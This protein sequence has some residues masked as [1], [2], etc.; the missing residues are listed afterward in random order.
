MKYLND[1]KGELAL[2]VLAV[3]GVCAIVIWAVRH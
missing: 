1:N 2:L 3:V